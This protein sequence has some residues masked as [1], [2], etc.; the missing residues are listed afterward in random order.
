VARRDNFAILDIYL[1]GPPM[2]GG[3]FGMFW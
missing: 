3:H 1:E 2:A